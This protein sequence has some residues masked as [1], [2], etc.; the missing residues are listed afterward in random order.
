MW[1]HIRH[2]GSVT[3]LP[4]AGKSSHTTRALTDLKTSVKFRQRF[5]HVEQAPCMSFEHS[6]TNLVLFGNNSRI[7]AMMWRGPIWKNYSTPAAK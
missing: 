3:K 7:E 4:D 1:K 6:E 5:Q 2:V